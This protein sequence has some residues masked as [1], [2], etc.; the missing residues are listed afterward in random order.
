MIFS[1]ELVVCE[2]DKRGSFRQESEITL[3]DK[4]GL[5]GGQRGHVLTSPRGPLADDNP[6]ERQELHDEV[7][8]LTIN[9]SAVLFIEAAETVHVVDQVYP[10]QV[11]TV[12]EGRVGPPRVDPPDLLR[13]PRQSLLPGARDP[14]VDVLR[15]G[16]RSLHDGGREADHHELGLAQG[17]PSEQ[18]HL[19]RQNS[20]PQC[21]ILP[22]SPL[23][24][25]CMGE[26]VR[27]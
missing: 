5:E 4:S 15:D 18:P 14:Q 20:P 16:V 3:G 21:P 10:V 24:S 13:R 6:L 12:E 25:R 11:R 26:S 1:I 17:E 27:L 2:P 23:E 9:G 22:A 8:D 19:R 7:V